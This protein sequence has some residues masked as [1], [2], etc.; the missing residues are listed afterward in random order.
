MPEVRRC[1][2]LRSSASPAPGKSS[3][4][5]SGGCEGCEA[6]RHLH[7]A[8]GNATV[9]D[10]KQPRDGEAAPPRYCPSIP[11]PGTLAEDLRARVGRS[12]QQHLGDF[13]EFRK[14]APPVTLGS[15]DE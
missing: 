9:P 7:G 1:V 4:S 3:T 5:K 6:F 8:T 11:I 14:D 15:H 13:L 2:F 12:W 10:R